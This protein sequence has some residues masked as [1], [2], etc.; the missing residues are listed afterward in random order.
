M[1][2]KPGLGGGD[3]APNLPTEAELQARFWMLADLIRDAEA[4]GDKAT[5]R[6]LERERRGISHQLDQSRHAR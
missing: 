3:R 2:D 6:R 5:A 4:S 1:P